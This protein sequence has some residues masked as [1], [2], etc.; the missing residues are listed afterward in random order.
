MAWAVVFTDGH[1]E[2]DSSGSTPP[3]RTRRNLR[4]GGIFHKSS[5]QWARRQN[6]GIR[7]VKNNLWHGPSSI[8]KWYH[9]G[10]GF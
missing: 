10:A 1:P 6:H 7:G 9:F 8:R 5:A 2:S 4:I 3:W